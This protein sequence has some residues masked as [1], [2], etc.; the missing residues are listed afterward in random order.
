M[1]STTMLLVT[2]SSS[3]SPYRSR[4]TI[5]YTAGLDKQ[6]VMDRFLTPARNF[7]S[8]RSVQNVPGTLQA[9]CSMRKRKISPGVK[10]LLLEADNL[11]L[12][13]TETWNEWSYT[14]APQYSF[15]LQTGTF[16]A[17]PSPTPGP[18]IFNPHEGHIIR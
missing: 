14:F 2:L 18:A 15:I 7:S 3:P 9:S 6:R 11:P 8:L 17:S 16:L 13:S 10:R 12:S 5:I 1:T 4:N